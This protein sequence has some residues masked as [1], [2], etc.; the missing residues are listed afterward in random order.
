MLIIFK[1]ISENVN[2]VF[3][4]ISFSSSVNIGLYVL[5]KIKGTLLG[6]LIHDDKFL[7]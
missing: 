2:N 7:V 5:V 4:L 3:M 6:I 1:K